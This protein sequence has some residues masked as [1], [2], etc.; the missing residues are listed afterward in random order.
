MGAILASAGFGAICGSSVAT[1]ATITSVALPEMRKAGYHPGFASGAL[2]AG[3]T[4][5]SL[6]PP[7]G[8]LIV[9]G[10]IAEQ[11]I[12][13][14]FAAAVVPGLSQAVFYMIAIMIL[15]AFVPALGP[16]TARVPARSIALPTTAPATAPS[17]ATGSGR[18]FQLSMNKRYLG[19]SGLMSGIA[20]SR[21]S[22]YS[23]VAAARPQYTTSTSACSRRPCRACTGRA[24][25]HSSPSIRRPS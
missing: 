14:L 21:T 20:V 23:S 15:C 4:L 12:G 24:H 17:T 22:S 8:A 5:G 16:A 3:G 13:K 19:L 10:I 1:A 6:I 18:R 9:F 2:A 7:S 25:R 11:S